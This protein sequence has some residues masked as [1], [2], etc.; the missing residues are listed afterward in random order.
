MIKTKVQMLGRFQP[1]L[2]TKNYLKKYLKNSQ[3]NIQVKNVK[4]IRDNPFSFS[5]I[6]KNY[7]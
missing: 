4:G 5:Q 6:K 3:V 1:C 7:G 2:A